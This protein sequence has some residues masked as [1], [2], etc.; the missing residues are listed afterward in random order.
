MAR[1]PSSL[2]S[3]VL[4]WSRWS[5]LSFVREK[6]LARSL[7]YAFSWELP[8]GVTRW[9]DIHDLHK[10][11]VVQAGAF[12][13]RTRRLVIAHD[14]ALGKWERAVYRNPGRAFRACLGG[15]DLEK[16][17]SSQRSYAEQLCDEY[18]RRH[19]IS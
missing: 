4:H 15:T 5:G 1:A 3:R 2:S 12:Y 9:L 17:L 6:G 18:L 13:S 10:Y 11:A 7:L 16:L 14:D 19:C 8:V